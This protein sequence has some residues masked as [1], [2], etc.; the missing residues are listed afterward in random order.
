[1]A[2]KTLKRQEFCFAFRII[3]LE[4]KQD[5]DYSCIVYYKKMNSQTAA[6]YPSLMKLPNAFTINIK[7]HTRIFV[8]GFVQQKTLIW[9]LLTEN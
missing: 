5:G 7:M 6:R 8:S 2:T 4:R 1:M 9:S 3:D